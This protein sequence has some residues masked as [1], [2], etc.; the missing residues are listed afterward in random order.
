MRRG[1]QVQDEIREITMQALTE[2]RFDRAALR[3]ATRDVVEAIHEASQTQGPQARRAMKDAV[4]GMDRAFADAAHAFRLSLKEA[5]ASGA[6]FARAAAGA[7]A[8]I[9]DSVGKPPAKR[10][11][12]RARRG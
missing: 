1:E 9:A 8:G 6:V 4:S 3:R 5:A 10:A 2:A 12:K 11:A 7:L